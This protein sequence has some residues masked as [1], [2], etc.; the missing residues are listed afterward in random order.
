MPTGPQIGDGGHLLFDSK[1]GDLDPSIGIR[2]YLLVAPVEEF[3]FLYRQPDLP[4]G[5]PAVDFREVGPKMNYQAGWK[6]LAV[7][8]RR[9][10]REHVDDDGVEASSEET[11]R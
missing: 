3:E 1:A 8:C 4:R 10:G 7:D 11:L 2:G 6:L 9:G 5:R